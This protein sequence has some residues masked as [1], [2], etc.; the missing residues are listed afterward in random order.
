MSYF[1]PKDA[2]DLV[3]NPLRHFVL[4]GVKVTRKVNAMLIPFTVR[5]NRFREFRSWDQT[6]LAGLFVKTVF[7]FGEPVNAADLTGSDSENCARMESM[8]EDLHRHADEVF[9]HRINNG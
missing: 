2:D 1:T 6:R 5:Y 4:L 3:S 8:L 7:Y 9:P